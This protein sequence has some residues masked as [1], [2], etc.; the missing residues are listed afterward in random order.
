VGRY[1]DALVIWRRASARGAKSR[2]RQYAI[3]SVH[4]QVDLG[5]AKTA[6]KSAGRLVAEDG[7]DPW[8]RLARARVRLALE[9]AKGASQD[10]HQAYAGNP[11]LADLVLTDERYAALKND[12]AC[13]KVTD[14]F[15]AKR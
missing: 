7:D 3:R 4:A 14:A 9:D 13:K 2:R 11:D 15:C 12:P 8:A 1:Q 6:L 5:G 10:L